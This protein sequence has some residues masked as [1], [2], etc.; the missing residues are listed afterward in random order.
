MKV[1]SLRLKASF[2]YHKLLDRR[3]RIKNVCANYN[4]PEARDLVEKEYDEAQESYSSITSAGKLYKN[5]ISKFES[6][7]CCPLCVRGY[8]NTQ[9]EEK[10]M[11][12]V[13][14]HITKYSCKVF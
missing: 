10:F 13:K 12:R 9:E 2:N 6:S 11:Q 8:D 5:F 3:T 7:H 14:T 4:F 1:K